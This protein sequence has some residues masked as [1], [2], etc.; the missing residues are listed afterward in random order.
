MAIIFE[1]A[2]KY[3]TKALN[4]ART[5]L[6]VLQDLE[7]ADQLAQYAYKGALQDDGSLLWGVIV[8]ESG[9]CKKD[10]TTSSL[11]FRQRYG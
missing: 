8:V 4:Q 10:K 9:T 7:K 6:N 3:G 11:C 2:E 5:T 1:Q